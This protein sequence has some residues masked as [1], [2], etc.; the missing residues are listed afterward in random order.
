MNSYYTVRAIQAYSDALDL[1]TDSEI[2]HE[3]LRVMQFKMYMKLGDAHAQRANVDEAWQEYRRALRMAQE[4]HMYIADDE[5]LALYERLAL[6]TTRWLG[7]F[8]KNPDPQEIRSYID[9]GL[10][11]LKGQ[12]ASREQVAFVTYLAFWYIRQL[13]TASYAQKAELAEQAAACVHVAL[14][15]AEELNNPSLLS[16]VLDA[17]SFVYDQYHNYHEAHQLQHQRQKLES[18]L[19]AREE[20]YD[21]YVSLG[22][23][24][25]AIA[26]YATALMWFGRAWTC[27]QSMESPALLLTCMAW[28]M[29]TWRQWNRW[30]EARQV[31]LDILRFIEQRQQ[32]E[33]KQLWALET[34]SVLAYR[35]GNTEE[36]DQY[37]RQYKRLIEQ[38]ESNNQDVPGTS[39]HAIHLAR[40]DWQRA[41]A[42]YQEKLRTSEPLPSPEIVSTLAELLVT[43]GADADL[44]EQ[45]CERAIAL[46]DTSQARKSMAIALRARGRMH[47][48]RQ[49]WDRAENDLQASLRMCEALDLPWERGNTLCCLGILYKQRAGTCPP[50]NAGEHSDDKGRA[51]YYFEQAL[52]FFESLNA[53]PAAQ[54]VRLTLA[55]ETTLQV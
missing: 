19:T 43:T 35:T 45:T 8:K 17:T 7:R 29:R 18:Q 15:Y 50:S 33:K 34:L 51:R 40:E 46:G 24:H 21:L 10:A 55:Q 48:E 4:E 16:L 3:A 41:T 49:Q 11:M 1:M 42:D 31:A 9:A 23:A 53:K 14:G 26:D 52:G 37:A 12:T 2:D 32:D 6:L 54:R 20:L 13:E 25:E 36:G 47:T 30:K 5:L 27:A 38:Q 39:M 22:C 44:Q 28:R